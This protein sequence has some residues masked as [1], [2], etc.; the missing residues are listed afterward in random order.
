M[1]TKRRVE[2][3]TAR[4]NHDGAI[5]R[6]GDGFENIGRGSWDF[7]FFVRG[8]RVMPGRTD[9]GPWFQVTDGRGTFWNAD[10]A[11]HRVAPRQ[12]FSL[13]QLGILVAAADRVGSGSL[14]HLA[15]PVL[16]GDRP[17]DAN[18]DTWRPA[19]DHEFEDLLTRR[20]PL[21]QRDK[22]GAVTLTPAGRAAIE[23]MAEIEQRDVALRFVGAVRQAVARAAAATPEEDRHA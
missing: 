15:F 17:D 6:F 11:E 8:L 2:H 1:A 7:G 4:T 3:Q 10:P 21:I 9:A 18:P 19:M 13:A 22:S 16:D 12:R 14:L 20:P 23:L 5:P